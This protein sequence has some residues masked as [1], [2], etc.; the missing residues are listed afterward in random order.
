ME[1]VLCSIIHKAKL[2]LQGIINSIV[3][4]NN[5]IILIVKALVWESLDLIISF[6]S[7]SEDLEEHYRLKNKQSQ[8]KKRGKMKMRFS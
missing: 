4:F 7:L 6:N 8:N 1:M 5:G 3:Y 2:K